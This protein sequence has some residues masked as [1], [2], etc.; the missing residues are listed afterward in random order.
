MPRNIEFG[1]LKSY[2]VLPVLYHKGTA[3][4][5]LAGL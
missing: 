3:L 2:T 5:D 4:A 1:Q